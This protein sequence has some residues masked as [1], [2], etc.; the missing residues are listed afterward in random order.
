MATCLAFTMNLAAGTA[1]PSECP[2]ISDAVKAKIT[3]DP[4]ED[5]KLHQ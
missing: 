1:Q 5:R 3:G 4:I 2:H